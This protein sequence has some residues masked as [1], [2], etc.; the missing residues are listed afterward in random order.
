MNAVIQSPRMIRMG[1]IDGIRYSLVVVLL[2]LSGIW[3]ASVAIVKWTLFVVLCMVIAT[4]GMVALLILLICGGPM[5]V[6]FLIAMAV[7]VIL[8]S[9]EEVG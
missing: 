3:E 4:V 9:L 1:L 8:W 6:G 5:G 2:F 7:V